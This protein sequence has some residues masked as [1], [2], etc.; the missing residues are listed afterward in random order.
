MA[1]KSIMTIRVQFVETPLFTD[2]VTAHLTDEQYSE[3]QA[4]MAENPEAGVVIRQ[5]GGLRKLRWT[6]SASG[7]CKRGGNR[8]I[9]VW[10]FNLITAGSAFPWRCAARRRAQAMAVALGKHGNAAAQR[11]GSARRV[12][13]S[14]S[15]AAL[16]PW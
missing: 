1:Y 16:R 8:V 12:G 6:D 14:A 4:Y 13:L 9:Y 2:Q 15:M 11:H 7:R 3:L 5:T 10:S